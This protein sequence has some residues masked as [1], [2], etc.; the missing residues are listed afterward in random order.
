MSS[1]ERDLATFLASCTGAR[2]H[3][4]TRNTLRVKVVELAEREKARLAM[5]EAGIG[6]LKELERRCD[7]VLEK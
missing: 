5:G 1:H 6:Q 3:D 4:G 2:S 7:Q